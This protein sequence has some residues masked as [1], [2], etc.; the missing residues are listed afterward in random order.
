MLYSKRA[1]TDL[2]CAALWMANA[3]DASPAHRSAER[4]PSPS[5]RICRR[6]SSCR[7][8]TKSVW[9]NE[10]RI[11]GLELFDRILQRSHIVGGFENPTLKL[12]LFI[13]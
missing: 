4:A 6:L 1:I 5:A 7:V 2:W 11:W 13:H 8:S 12:V 9:K 10:P 3:S